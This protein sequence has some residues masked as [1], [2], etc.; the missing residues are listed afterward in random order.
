MNVIWMHFQDFSMVHFMKTKTN[1]IEI[2]HP[3]LFYAIWMQQALCRYDNIYI[4]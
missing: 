3:E 2:Y 4:E 1:L